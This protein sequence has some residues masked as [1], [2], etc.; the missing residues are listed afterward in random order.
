[1]TRSVRAR[2]D[3]IPTGPYLVLD[4]D[5]CAAV[6]RAP[7]DV[8]AAAARAG[9]AV[10]QVRAKRAAVRELVGLTTSVADALTNVAGR[11]VLVVD[12]RVD[13][14]L[15]ARWRGARVD[16]VH[17]GQQDLEAADARALLGPDAVVGVSAARPAQVRA[18]DPAVVDYVGTGPVRLTATKPEADVAVGFDGLVRAVC[19]TVLPVVAIGG[20]A[21]RD[22]AS[23]AATGA[24]GLAVVTAICAAADPGAAARDLVERWGAAQRAARTSDVATAPVGAA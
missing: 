11:V 17:L 19:G 4:A 16:G 8:A 5:V 20:L 22:A 24:H 2:R 15:A 3:A 1:M 18:V 10:V 21:A 14:V 9:V 12:D 23:V 6:G 13:V 7:R